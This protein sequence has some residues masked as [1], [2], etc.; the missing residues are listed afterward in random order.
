MP[1]ISVYPSYVTRLEKHGAVVLGLVGDF[2]IHFTPLLQS[3][4]EDALVASPPHIVVDLSQTQFLDSSALG[5]L[6][7]ADRRAKESD[8]WLRTVSPA[9]YVR[10]VLR[11][12]SLD[13][14]FGVYDTVE[15]AT[16][17]RDGL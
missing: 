6:Y 16:D 7:V 9:A 12:T 13:T 10:K 11:V 2:D 15:Q 3:S 1:A 14:V 4:L 5:V 8:G 17:D